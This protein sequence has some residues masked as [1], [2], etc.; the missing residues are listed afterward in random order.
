MQSRAM[1]CDCFQCLG[2]ELTGK[3]FLALLRQSK[4]LSESRLRKISSLIHEQALANERFAVFHTQLQQE[5]AASYRLTESSRLYR[6]WGANGKV[7]RLVE[8]SSAKLP[9]HVV[10]ELKSCYYLDY[11]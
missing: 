4:L 6:E 7:K 8:S 10:V 3:Q 9:A 1:P 11:M 5:E 2:F